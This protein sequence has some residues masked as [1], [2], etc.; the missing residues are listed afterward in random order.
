MK[1]K[2][3]I[4][5]LIFVLLAG[6]YS[7]IAVY[8]KTSDEINQE[9]I[10]KQK[11][12]EELAAKLKKAQDTLKASEANKNSTL[13]EIE[14][15]KA[16]LTDVET[17]LEINE[18]E[19]QNLEQTISL[20]SLQ[21]EEMQKVQDQEITQSYIIWK[22]NSTT[23]QIIGSDDFLKTAVYQEYIAEESRRQILG[24]SAELNDLEQTSETYAVQIGELEKDKTALAEKKKSLEQKIA[25]LNNTI[26]SS[27]SNAGSI[28]GQMGQV[29]QRIEQLTEEQKAILAEENKLVGGGPVDDVVIISG[30]LFF[31]GTGRDLYQGHGVGLSQF[32]AYGAAQKGW[33][34]EQILNFYYTQ[35]RVEERSGTISVQ[36]YGVMDLNDYVAGLG[37]VPD[38]A[39]GNQEQVTQNPQKY[40]IDNPNTVWDCWP[41]EAIKAQVIA[42]RSYAA[43]Y[44]GTICTTA[45]CQVYEGGNAKRWAAD[46]TLN[47]VII[48]SGSTHTNQIIRALYSSDNSQGYGTANNDTVWSNFEGVG[49]PY[50]Y[51]RHVNDN[52]IAAKFSYTN[53]KWKTNSYSLSDL[54]GFLTWAANNYTTGGSNNFLKGVKNGVG[55]LQSITFVRDGSNRVK[56]V[57]LTGSNGTK[58]M[59]G[60]LYKAVWN[61]WVA[62]VKPKGTTDY[63]YSLT[64]F[65][66]TG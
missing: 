51:L 35:T 29:Q 58:V 66:K 19:R 46:E 65:L 21:K 16:E 45:S 52:H 20:K 6:I 28:R 9:I 27:S 13:S 33:T 34:A 60:W 41:E 31:E 49:T 15:V 30:E 1:S 12:L 14:R 37:E 25:S 40:V 44:S 8:A 50:S 10:A 7:P 57:R 36:G 53:W 54:N 38:K 59:S 48:S 17:Q 24:I 23:T 4:F 64:W 2:F 32:G 43:S 62:N 22:T 3:V 26:A 55:E 42:A 11:E 5:S 63:I 39:C 18:L 47:K 61:S 56:Q